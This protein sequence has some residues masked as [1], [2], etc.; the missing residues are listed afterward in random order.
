[1]KIGLIAEVN[2]FL[3]QNNS[4]KKLF[5]FMKYIRDKYYP[6]LTVTETTKMLIEQKQENNKYS[7]LPKEKLVKIREEYR[8]RYEKG[9]TYLLEE[10]EEINKIL[11]TKTDISELLIKTLIFLNYNKVKLTME[12]LKQLT[13]KEL[14]DLI[15]E[16]SKINKEISKKIGGN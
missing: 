9:E 6:Y 2:E 5:N 11:T 12:D 1:M 3:Q 15:N 14:E 4:K 10:I 7:N 8:K 16:I 13:I